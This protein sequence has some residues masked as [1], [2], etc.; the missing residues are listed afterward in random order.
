MAKKW[1]GDN[2]EVLRTSVG[3]RVP[4]GKIEVKIRE[5]GADGRETSYTTTMALDEY[6]SRVRLGAAAS[7]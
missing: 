2:Q 6:R 1:L 3:G 5:V 7:V 4:I